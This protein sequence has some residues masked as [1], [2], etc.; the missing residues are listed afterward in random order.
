MPKGLNPSKWE[1]L[2]VTKKHGSLMRRPEWQ[3][4]SSMDSS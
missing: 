4:A 3:I 2:G 1:V